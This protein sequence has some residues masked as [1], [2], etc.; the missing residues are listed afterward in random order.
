MNDAR[1][2]LRDL[3]RH[4]VRVHLLPDRFRLEPAGVAVEPLRHALR[5]YAVEVKVLL[6]ELPAPDRCRVCGDA[7]RTARPNDG[8]LQCVECCL[9]VAERRGWIVLP[10]E[11]ERAA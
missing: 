8:N 6:S 11:Q 2:L 3:W 1:D 9:I 4:G 5:E 7:V 10:V